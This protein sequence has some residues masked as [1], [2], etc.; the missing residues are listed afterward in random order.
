[1]IIKTKLINSLKQNIFSS[2]VALATHKKLDS[3]VNEKTGIY[4]WISPVLLKPCT[5]QLFF[6]LS[7]LGNVGDDRHR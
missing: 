2:F 1:V 3:F 5:H 7:A 6:Y 4:F